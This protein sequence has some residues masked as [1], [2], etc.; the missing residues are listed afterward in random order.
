[1]TEPAPPLVSVII[2]TYNRWPLVLEAIESVR[3][4]T[5]TDYELIVVVDVKTTDGSADRLREEGLPLRVIEAGDGLGAARNRGVES[6]RGRFV[7]FLDDDDLYEP[8]HLANFAAALQRAP[9]ADFFATRAWLWDPDADR[10]VEMNRFDPEGI[11][12]A[13]LLGT[14]ISPVTMF[15][16]RATNLEVGGFVEGE[17]T[18]DWLYLAR[19]S[20]KHQVV[21]IPEASVRIREHAGRS[22]RNTPV[23]IDKCERSVAIMLSDGYLDPPLDARQRA[24]LLAG[25]ERFCAGNLYAVGQM[26]QARSRLAAA[27]RHLPL[28]EGWRFTGKLSLQTFAGRWGSRQLRRTRERFMWRRG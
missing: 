12:E 3:S 6:A 16:R 9:D 25:A 18:E 20:Q 17:V 5:F 13:N 26:R 2:P 22:V 10:R 21:P 15:S 28:I 14:A 11:F 27:R 7:A 24:M 8:N 19:V 23:V 1:M 4:Q